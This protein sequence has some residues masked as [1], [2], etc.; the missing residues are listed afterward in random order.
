MESYSNPGGQKKDNAKSIKT[1][2]KLGHR[3]LQL[4]EYESAVQCL[5]YIDDYTER[6]QVK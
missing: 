2:E 5:L 6:S 1:L 3:N 4:D